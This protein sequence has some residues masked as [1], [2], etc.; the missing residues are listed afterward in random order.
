[1][2]QREREF[3]RKEE[4]LTKSETETEGERNRK[5]GRRGEKQRSHARACA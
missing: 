2:T 3:G 4:G 5:G 1:M